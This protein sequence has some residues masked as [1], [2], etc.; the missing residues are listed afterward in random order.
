MKVQ[1]RLRPPA[2]APF[3]TGSFERWGCRHFSRPGRGR[4]TGF[5]GVV[6]QFGCSTFVAV[7]SPQR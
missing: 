1:S 5:P 4:E 6:E 2:P 7:L 3:V